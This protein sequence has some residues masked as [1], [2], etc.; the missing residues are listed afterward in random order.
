[1]ND[2]PMILAIK[3]TEEEIVKIIS[4][5]GLPAFFLRYILDR[6]EKDLI[7]IEQNE[8]DVALKKYNEDLEK[9]EGE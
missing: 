7:L 5:A 3:E 8:L 4:K 9:K 6:I 2:K 1:M